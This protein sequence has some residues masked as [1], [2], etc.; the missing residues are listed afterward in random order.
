MDRAHPITSHQLV[1]I[2]R[3]VLRQFYSQFPLEPVPEAELG[4]LENRLQLQTER[5]RALAPT[6][7]DAVHQR[8]Y[9]ETPKRLDDN[10]WRTRML[11][12]EIAHSL[13]GL[14]A[15][16]PEMAEQL[17]ACRETL[18]QAER[19]VNQTQKSNTEAAASQVK[20]F[21]PQD[22]RASFVESRRVAKENNN[23]KA[24]DD[25]V[26]KG[27]SIRER[28]DLLMKQQWE[29]RE[30]LVQLGNLSGIYKF[31][32]KYLGGVPQVLLDFAKEINAKI[33][34]MEEQ[35]LKYGPDIYL[36]TTLGV[37]LNVLAA[38][39]LEH[40]EANAGSNQEL[41]DV[42]QPGINFYCHHLVRVISFLGGIFIKSPFFVTKD[43]VQRAVAATSE[44]ASQRS[45]SEKSARPSISAMPQ[46]ALPVRDADTSVQEDDVAPFFPD[47]NAGTQADTILAK[48]S[49]A[50]D[51]SLQGGG[52]TGPAAAA[53]AA[54]Q[55][56]HFLPGDV[57]K[58]P[59]EV[60]RRR[61][62]GEKAVVKPS[63]GLSDVAVAARAA[64]GMHARPR[65]THVAID[66]AAW[67]QQHH[68]HNEHG[69]IERMSVDPS[70][71][72]GSDFFM[73]CADNISSFDEESPASEL[74]SLRHSYEIP[75]V[76]LAYESTPINS[77]AALP[78]RPS[79]PLS[80]PNANQAQPPLSS[81]APAPTPAPA[82]LASPP[83]SL[84]PSAALPP[85]R[86]TSGSTSLQVHNPSRWGGS[87][88]SSNSSRVQ[89][90]GP[91]QSEGGTGHSQTAASPPA[92]TATPMGDAQ[93]GVSPNALAAVDFQSSVTMTSMSSV[94]H[95]QGQHL[96]QSH[97]LPNNAGGTEHG[98]EVG[99]AGLLSSSQ[100]CQVHRLGQAGA[101]GAAGGETS[102]VTGP[103]TTEGE[104]G[105]SLGTTSQA[106]VMGAASDI[107]TV[108]S[109]KP[110][111]SSVGLASVMEEDI[112]PGKRLSSL[113]SFITQDGSHQ[114]PS[115]LS[116]QQR[117]SP[118]HPQQQQQQQQPPQRQ[119]QQSAAAQPTPDMK[120]GCCIV[121]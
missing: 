51:G 72:A 87:S 61:S 62:T 68:L 118:L 32:I 21:L 101:A 17:S 109:P 15:K 80:A 24:V 113:N 30:A 36:I 69:E 5:L 54:A 71:V 43:D 91:S 117:M 38:L 77:A 76:S 22:F 112:H 58:A 33:G 55:P 88:N 52:I 110:Y 14:C 103:T 99:A 66:G 74:H 120:G 37:R 119:Q 41:W 70:T 108:G 39:W 105:S 92:L 44:T 28:Y 26:K 60:L 40:A 100:S 13:K 50:Q 86:M 23:T 29:R 19:E 46:A 45:G 49:S 95:L 1:P 31:L 97:S 75:I 34:P 12:E 121:Q 63:N 78:P 104:D 79:P 106:G 96:H 67:H 7:A 64:G 27:G 73:S 48:L 98:R 107:A 114:A 25:L 53:A 116:T 47:P 18:M 6:V 82:P 89:A 2:T 16:L 35:R 8:F 83:A 11:S 111:E 56:G 94:S 9:M 4:E 102:S 90:Y 57:D 20:R 85:L 93:Q 10:F 115:R 81:S 59:L 42:L 3:E 65:P 84:P